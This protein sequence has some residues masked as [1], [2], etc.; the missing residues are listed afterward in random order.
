MHSNTHSKPQ[1][2]NRLSAFFRRKNQTPPSIVP[3]QSAR[4]TRPSDTED[5]LDRKRTKGQYVK[6]NEML[7]K[8]IKEC[9]DQWSFDFA[10]LNGELE[11]VYD[12]Q[13][14]FKIDLM[15]EA[16]KE[17]VNDHTA[18]GKCG[19]AIQ[20]F[21][22]AFNPLA[23]NLFTIAKEGSAVFSIIMTPL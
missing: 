19:H 1:K 17:K 10:E 12:T 14:K 2:L 21:F 16:Y 8:A 22:T 15:L 13:F 6:A 3:P 4:N 5:S 18:L 7:Q 9:G 20:H 23:K 11:N